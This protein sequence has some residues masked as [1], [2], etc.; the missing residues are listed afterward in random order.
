MRI[1]LTGTLGSGKSTALSIF[2]EHG[3][4]TIDCDSI[5]KELIKS[6]LPTGQSLKD[7]FGK[8]VCKSEDLIDTRA[9]ADIVFN[10][11]EELKWLEALLHP[12]VRSV[13]TSQ[14]EEHPD[15]DWVV[16]IPLLFENHL[17]DTWDHTVCLLTNDKIQ[18]ERLEAKGYTLEQ[19]QARIKQQMPSEEKAARADFVITNNGSLDALKE[20]I[21]ILI[22]SIIK[23]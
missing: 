9:L 8:E 3:F 16:E 12:K 21:T 4:S 11:P 17:E 10:N 19:A 13:W 6:D 7:H 1:A 20:Q 18:L 23:H 2:A 14:L 22:N 15:Q 5:V